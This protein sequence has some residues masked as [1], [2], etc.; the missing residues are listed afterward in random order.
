MLGPGPGNSVIYYSF[1]LFPSSS[2]FASPLPWLCFPC[3]LFVFSCSR[4]TP[5]LLT[6]AVFFL[7]AFY[8]SFNRTLLQQFT[9]SSLWLSFTYRCSLDY[10]FCSFSYPSP[11][12][13]WVLYRAACSVHV[14]NFPA[15]HPLL[16]YSFCCCQDANCGPAGSHLLS[17]EVCARLFIRRRAFTLRFAAFSDREPHLLLHVFKPPFRTLIFVNAHCDSL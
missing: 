17:T 9:P 16:S 2:G 7:L 6:H 15:V 1:S 11:L 14:R 5:I 3:L 10:Y 13:N 4:L 8:F 12:C